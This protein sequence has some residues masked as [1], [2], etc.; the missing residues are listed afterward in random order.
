MNNNYVIETFIFLKVLCE[1]PSVSIPRVTWRGLSSASWHWNLHG[2]DTRSTINAYSQ[3]DHKEAKGCPELPTPADSREARAHI[4][5][6]SIWG[7]AASRFVLSGHTGSD[8]PLSLPTPSWQQADPNVLLT[9]RG[10]YAFLRRSN[11]IRNP[12]FSLLSL[13]HVF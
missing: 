7:P 11:E 6:E 3:N 9:L 10:S 12:L 5:P 2:V 1:V 4:L 13:E 8:W